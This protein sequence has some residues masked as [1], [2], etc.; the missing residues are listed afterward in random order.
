MPISIHVY[1][2]GMA[3]RSYDVA[4]KLKTSAAAEGGSKQAAACQFKVCL[5]VANEPRLYTN[6]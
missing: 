3:C 6:E 1:V 5:G 4:V 2:F